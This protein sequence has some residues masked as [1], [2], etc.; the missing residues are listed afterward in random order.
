LQQILFGKL[1]PYSAGHDPVISAYRLDT[2]SLTHSVADW[3]VKSGP[4]RLAAVGSGV[5]DV[6]LY[7]SSRFRWAKYR[8]SHTRPPY[9]PVGPTEIVTD[10]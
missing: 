8:D 10:W 4:R 5:G 6:D 1:S 2:Y 7:D 3:G 9:L